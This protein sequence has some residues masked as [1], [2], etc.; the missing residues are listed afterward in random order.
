MPKPLLTTL[1]AIVV[2]YFTAAA[3][4]TTWY[5]GAWT[6]TTPDKAA[7]FQIKQKTDSGW[8][9]MGYFRA[10]T[11]QSKA[12]YSD[13][14]LHTLEGELCAY[15]I[16]GILIHL[17]TYAN[18]KRNGPEYWYH[19]NGK[20]LEKGDNKDGNHDGP[21]IGYY[22]SGKLAGTV[23]YVSGKETDV[24]LYNE[25][26]STKDEKVFEREAQF[27]GGPQ[28]WLRY[29]NQNLHY[30]DYAVNHNIKGTVVVQFKT[31]KTGKIIESAVIKSVEKHI[32]AE[33]LRIIR[34]S[35]DWEPTLLAGLPAEAY[36]RQPIV[37]KMDVM[38][39]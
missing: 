2:S 21:W 26:G 33:A 37:F 27:P 10:G 30:P 7:Y 9:V 8:L 6:K 12:L 15:N 19:D 29:M 31:T 1:I 24:K 35:P 28:A 34:E 18:G 32:D 5:S 17:C 25:D 13:D 16:K 4:D 3:Q 22:P 36:K 39:K 20:E 23:T 14:S 11:I 38:G